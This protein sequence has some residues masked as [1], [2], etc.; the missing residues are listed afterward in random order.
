MK[1]I[2]WFTYWT[3]QEFER[4]GVAIVG[5][6]GKPA[7]L[8]PIVRDLNREVRVL[9]GTLLRLTSTGVFHTGGV[10]AGG[11]RLGSDALVQ[12]PA[13]APLVLG[14]FRDP[15]GAEFV[16][17]VN[18][19]YT[20][21]V[22]Y[23]VSFR[24]HIASAAE[25]NA[26]DGALK[27]LQV[28]NQRARLKLRPGDG[29]LL[30]LTTQ[31]AYPKA[32]T[33]LT[34]IRFEFNDEGEIDDWGHPNSLTPPRG[35]AGVMTMTFT[36]D[37][38]SISRGNLRLAP[39]SVTRIRVRMKLPSCNVTGQLFWATTD[40]PNFGDDKHVDFS[41]QPDGAFH[42]YEIPVGKH[43]KWRGK[44]VTLIRLDPTTGGA[45]PG[46]QVEIDYLRGE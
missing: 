38:P 8:F 27:P 24:P 12:A 10:P 37:D 35:H 29:R 17:V 32:S 28:S 15:G 26:T 4:E 45:A 22:E 2:G 1:G 7:R 6:D 25:V 5:M 42:E 44:T 13:D 20:R 9:G 11:R 41:V 31:F 14:F 33:P 39:G 43:P 18:R 21:P 19:D 16:M 34:A 40:E 46:S 23:E 30:R 3:I 36:G